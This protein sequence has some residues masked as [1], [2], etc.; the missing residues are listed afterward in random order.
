[1]ARVPSPLS[2][3]RIRPIAR[4]AAV[5]DPCPLCSA[6]LARP[7]AASRRRCLSTPT[8]G[9]FV[10]ECPECAGRWEEAPARR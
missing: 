9:V 10:W 4:R 8:P 3:P 6:D 7:G 1:M 2:R 5:P